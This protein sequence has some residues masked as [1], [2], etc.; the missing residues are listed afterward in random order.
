MTTHRKAIVTGAGGHIGYHVAK[1]LLAREVE[2]H[3]IVRRI[4]DNITELQA[5]GAV[6]H[7]ADLTTTTGII[8]ILKDADALFHLAAE[9]TTDT[10]DPERV[11]RNTYNLACTVIDAAIT[12]NVKTIIY[13]S[14]VVVLGRSADK[15]IL[16][17]E[18]SLNKNPES[19]YVKGKLMAEIY[20]REKVR[21]SAADIRI[22]YPSWVVGSGD[23]RGTPPHVLIRQYLEKGQK[24]H[25]DG[26]ISVASV[27]DIALGHVEAW[28]KGNKQARY[29]LGGQNITFQE[30]YKVLSKLT[31][32]PP[33][34]FKVPKSAL[35]IAAHLLKLLPIK[36]DVPAPEYIKAVAGNYS[37]YNSNKA[38]EELGYKI[39][40]K[41]QILESG[42]QQAAGMLYQT[43][44]IRNRYTKAVPINYEEDDILLIT[45]FPG[46]LTNRMVD[47]MIN[48]NTFGKD[49]INRK[50]RL[51]THS[52]YQFKVNLPS[53][54][55][56]VSGDLKDINSLRK[57]LSGVKAVYH[58]AGVIFS[59]RTSEFYKVNHEGT[60]NL[61][62]ACIESG[63]H[64]FIFMSTDSVC[65]YSPK[66][67]IF[68]EN[69]PSHPYKDY[70]K[71]KFLAE[72][73]LL[74]KTKQNTI[75]GTILRGFWF[76]G[77]YAPGR[78]NDF[79]K[80]FF[81][82]RQIIFGNGKNFRSI[83]H[84]DNLTHAFIQCEKNRT[85]IG[86]WY[87]I[88]EGKGTLTVESIYKSIAEALGTDLRPIHIP[89]FLCN[90]LSLA[91][92]ILTKFGWMNPTIYSAGKFHKN[93]AATSEKAK[94]DFNYAPLYDLQQITDEIKSSNK[95]Y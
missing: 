93:I 62:D 2:T 49:K 71:S 77:P 64:R 74:E 68:S 1:E 78:V 34:A 57:A 33:T 24:F 50:V 53:N 70:G 65:G 72:Q 22:V 92:I 14:S 48:G 66:N 39:A 52:R 30:F 3:V 31:G 19:P 51:L 69:E 95:T 4:N 18:N 41:E 23:S 63:V 28:L 25:F 73:Y 11:I 84:V 9:N 94:V 7:L 21:D 29:V 91:D 6:V 32:N 81:W 13:T 89:N 43:N 42:I 83:T 88:G 75:D 82:K 76:F 58:I 87:W 46:W 8:P 38:M 56:I 26:G 55:E 36:K 15:R 80:M 61:I 17:D 85:T 59:S 10:S 20:C 86:K 40:G 45:G 16:L 27:E 79:Y 47:I 35:V 60:R 37:W 5:S 44:N 90:L 54:F 67:K 12:A